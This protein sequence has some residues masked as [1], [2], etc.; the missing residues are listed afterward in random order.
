MTWRP[1]TGREQLVVTTASNIGAAAACIEVA[2]R[3][4]T[5]AIIDNPAVPEV[6]ADAL[7]ELNNAAVVLEAAVAR[8]LSA[9]SVTLG[10]Q[11]HQLASFVRQVRHEDSMARAPLR[12]RPANARHHHVL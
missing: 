6:P 7:M 4:L 2:D 9:L 1:P 3:H 5:S 8:A 11:T 10:E 12:S